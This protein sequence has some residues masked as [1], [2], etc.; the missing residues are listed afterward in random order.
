MP[1]VDMFRGPSK[2]Q[3]LNTGWC[4]WGKPNKQVSDLAHLLIRIWCSPWLRPAGRMVT[5]LRG[6]RLFLN[7]LPGTKLNDRYNP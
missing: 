7:Q 1:L 2:L 5:A 3:L 4:N 6:K